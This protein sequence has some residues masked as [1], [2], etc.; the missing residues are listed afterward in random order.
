MRRPMLLRATPSLLGTLALAALACGGE[1]EPEP[2]VADPSAT[3]Q[4]AEG[5]LVGYAG[6]YG[7]HAWRGIPFATPP[8]GDRRWRAPRPP[9]GWEGTRKA[10]EQPAACPQFALPGGEVEAGQPTGEEDCLY[11]N[12]FAPRMTPEEVPEGAERLPVMFWI[13]GGGNTLGDTRVYNGGRLAEVHDVIVVTV[14]YRLGAFGWFT[15]PS[16]RL[17]G[18]DGRDLSGNWGT[19]DLIRALD[20]TRENIAA[21]GG[22][23]GN[24]TIF[25]ESAGGTN[26]FSLLVSPLAR[27][28]FQRAIVQSGGLWTVSRAEAENL[29]DAA[30]PGHDF[31]SGEVLLHLLIADGAVDRAAA[32]VRLAA[33]SPPEVASYLRGK[34]AYEI[35]GAYDGGDMAMYDAPLLIRDGVVMPAALPA[36]VLASGGAAD[37][38]TI[39]GTNRDETKLFLVFSSQHVTRAFGLPLWLKDETQ[40]DLE[41]EYGSDSWRARGVDEPAEAMLAGRGSGLYGYRFDWDEEPTVLFADFSKLLGAAHALEIPF[42]FGTL[43]L[44]RGNRFLWDEERI[45]A[46]DALSDAMMSY[47]AHFAY[48]GDP[49]RGRSGTLAKW[50]AWDGSGPR[51]PRS[52]VFD[53]PEDGGIRMSSDRITGES[54][55]AR[56]EQDDRFAD[57]RGRCGV[58]YGFLRFSELIDEP[59]YAA[60]CPDFPA[61]DYP[62]D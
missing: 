18:Y 28:R 53:T 27:D 38:P 37:V 36:E 13:H 24:I 47:W 35:L 23:P 33:M 48:T 16:L 60:R 32:K 43:D 46:R 9:E 4:V 7:D 45:P 58:Y 52:L 34:S 56:L 5:S 22:D 29:S 2:R 6:D 1:P 39:L 41:S 20:W 51:A 54:L 30:E 55:L 8:V 11:L 14:Q 10:L 44:G 57:E 25:G 42:V 19:L 12:V 40:Y 26:V 31:S 17:E 50:H 59:D 62:W 15:H 3:R 21:F 61:D 49:A